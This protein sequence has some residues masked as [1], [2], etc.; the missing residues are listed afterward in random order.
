[1]DRAR[2]IDD[3]MQLARAGHLD[4]EI[5]LNTTTYL[6]SEQDYIVWLAADRA[7]SYIDTMLE[8]VSEYGLL[9]VSLPDLLQ[10]MS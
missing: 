4:Q 9:R 5:A 10:G 8:S 7:F 6:Q 2:L 1:M 3:S